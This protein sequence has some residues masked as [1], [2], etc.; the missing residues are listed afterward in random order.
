MFD[1]NVLLTLSLLLVVIVLISL[2][3]L[4][5]YEHVAV[6]VVFVGA[7]YFRFDLIMI[8]CLCCNIC[9]VLLLLI[10]S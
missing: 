7:C 3:L 4:L 6:Y 10:Y 2:L 9:N 1:V 8:T 5:F